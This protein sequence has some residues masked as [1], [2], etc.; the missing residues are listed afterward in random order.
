MKQY[1]T[2][3]RYKNQIYVREIVDGVEYRR[4]VRFQPYIF[5]RSSKPTEY[6]DFYG[7]QY[8]KKISF[9]NPFEM[10]EHIDMYKDI[11]GELWGNKDI[12][13]QF[14]YDEKYDCFD[15]NN[16]VVS[17]L[18][19][20]VC[21]RSMGENGEWI[22]GGF[23]EAIEAKF[24]IN[25][26]CDYR[27]NT[28]KY[29]T[30]TTAKGWTMSK[31]QLKYS[32]EVEYIYCKDEEDL[33]K[34]WLSF[35]VKNCPHICTN[36]NGK[37]FDIPYIINRLKIL[38]GVDIAARIS[39]FNVIESKEVSAGFGNKQQSYEIMGVA[40]LDYLDLYKKYRYVPREKYTLDFI[41]RAEN[42]EEH[43]LEFK[44]THGSLYYDDPVFFIDYNIQ[45]VRCVVNFEKKLQLIQLATYLSYFSN[46]NFEDNYSPIKIWETIIAKS[47]L[48]EGFVIPMRFKTPEKK[49]YEGA[50]VHEPVPGLKGCIASFDYTSLY[51]KIMELFYI[52]ADVHQTGDVKKKLFEELLKVLDNGDEK[53]HSMLSEIKTTGIFND[54][55]INNDIPADVT[56]FLKERGV[57]LTTNC[58]FY[59]VSKKSIFVSLITKLFLERK[60]DKKTSFKF[61]HQAQEIKEELKKRGIE[62]PEEH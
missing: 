10:K 47:C 51:P 34:K 55:Y 29:H 4:K 8:V 18:D 6:K 11:S 2:A 46:I 32:D 20:E 54:F 26:I 45:D 44:G 7:N 61:K 19:I 33:L 23:P 58:E 1:I 39:P 40:I 14:M 60:S 50:Y 27:S 57:S 25:A 37:L 30:F 31:S 5:Q 35:W 62:I 16:L 21:T 43:K 41:S 49:P 42:P 15:F 48:D 9:Q 28:K 17:Y 56:K 12:V 53:C 24:P 13:A 22:D 52:G 38:F 3:N 59:D 36:W